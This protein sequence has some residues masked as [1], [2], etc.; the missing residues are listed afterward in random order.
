MP[1][2]EIADDGTKLFA[3]FHIAARNLV[4]LGALAQQAD[5]TFS[6]HYKRRVVSLAKMVRMYEQRDVDKG[7]AR[8][9]NWERVPLAEDQKICE[10]VQFIRCM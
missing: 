5:P 3:D 4:E 6:A 7:S 10:C 1:Q 9:S 8:L 2:R